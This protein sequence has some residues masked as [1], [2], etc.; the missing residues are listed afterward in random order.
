MRYSNF[1]Q[2][3]DPKLQAAYDKCRETVSEKLPCYEP[4]YLAAR[5][6]YHKL[7]IEAGYK[8]RLRN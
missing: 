3:K 2:H 7:L 1:K 4:E 6:E 8:L 5:K